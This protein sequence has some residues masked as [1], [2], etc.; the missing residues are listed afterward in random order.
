MSEFD[1]VEFGKSIGAM[2]REAVEP[3]KAEIAGLKLELAEVRAVKGEPGPKGDPGE[4]VLVA[5]VVAELVK[6]DVLAPVLDVYATEAVAKHFEEH[7]VQHGKDGAQGPRGEPGVQGEKGLDG[8]DG[9]GVA[10]LLIDRD[11]ALVA[12]MT[13]GRVKSLGKVVGSDGQPGRDGKDGADF[14]DAE[15]DYDGDRGL[16]IRG[17]GGEI[18]KRLPIPMDRGYYREG[19]KA[20]KGDILTHDGNAWL[21]LKDTSAKPCTENKEDWRIFARKGRDGR[22]GKDGKAPP[23]PVRLSD[24]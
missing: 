15:L 14:S 20:E 16:I 12:T 22:D 1:P 23:G 9:A 17:K 8:K 10:D 19:M 21:A 7:P 3:L 24:G 2:L 5:D 13:D 6:T 11:G 4:P 18:V